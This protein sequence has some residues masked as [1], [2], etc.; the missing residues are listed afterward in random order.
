MDTAQKRSHL[1][2]VLCGAAAILAGLI[3]MIARFVFE[4]KSGMSALLTISWITLF[5]MILYFPVSLRN[6]S[7]LSWGRIGV[8]WIPLA[9]AVIFNWIFSAVIDGNENL[10]LLICSLA[11]VLF[12][13][14]MQIIGMWGRSGALGVILTASM[15]AVYSFICA[16]SMEFAFSAAAPLVSLLVFPLFTLYVILDLLSGRSPSRSSAHSPSAI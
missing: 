10:P 2:Q 5:L 15:L 4:M 13:I 1:S 8:M 11:I 3:H 16:I 12:A 14:V 6:R 7:K 9:G